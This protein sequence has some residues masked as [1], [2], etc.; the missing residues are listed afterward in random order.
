MQGQGHQIFTPATFEGGNQQVNEMVNQM[1]PPQNPQDKSKDHQNN[2][3]GD[4]D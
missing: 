2:P 1:K 4:L 3:G